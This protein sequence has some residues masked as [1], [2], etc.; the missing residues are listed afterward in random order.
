MSRILLFL[1]L[2]GCTHTETTFTTEVYRVEAQV[3]SA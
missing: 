3:V 2:V 1:I